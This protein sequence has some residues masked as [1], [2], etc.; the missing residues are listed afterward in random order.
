MLRRIKFTSSRALAVVAAGVAP[1]GRMCF[2]IAGQQFRIVVNPLR[3]R[4]KNP[5]S[6]KTQFHIAQNAAKLLIFIA[7]KSCLI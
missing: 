1:S 7:M 3:R 4:S 5:Q 6:E 2:R